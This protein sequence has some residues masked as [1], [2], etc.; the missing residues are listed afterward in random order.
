MRP[1]R[2]EH[3][4]LVRRFSRSNGGIREYLMGEVY[5]SPGYPDGTRIV[6]SALVWHDE[7][8]ALTSSGA[9]YLLVGAP[10]RTQAPDGA[11]DL[12][13]GIE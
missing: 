6:T 9:R 1:H 12:T 13:Q 3:W 8:E 5:D 10:E 2:L 4:S 7:R 11:S